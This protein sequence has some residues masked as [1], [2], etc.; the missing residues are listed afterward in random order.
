ME[1]KN[2]KNENQETKYFK[3]DDDKVISERHI[4]WVKKM[5]SCLAVCS[6]YNGCEDTATH[7]IC[8]WNN[9]TSYKILNKH[10]E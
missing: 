5:G 3:T 6:K 9:P 1:K 2:E 7:K 10:F 8:E 4:R